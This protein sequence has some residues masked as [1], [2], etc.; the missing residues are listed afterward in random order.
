M[1]LNCNYTHCKVI[2]LNRYIEIY[3][4]ILITDRYLFSEQLTY[5]YDI[6]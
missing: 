4:N 3:S 2:T 5:I 6:K 1:F